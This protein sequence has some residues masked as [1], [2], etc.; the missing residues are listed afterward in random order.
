MSIQTLNDI[1]ST[2]CS[3]HRDRVMLHR[4]ASGWQSISSSDFYR[5]V[6]GLSRALA[7]WGV[8]KGDR[9]AILSENRPEWTITDFAALALGAVTVPI[10]ATQ[11]ADQCAFI[12]NDAGARIVAVSTHHQLEKVLSVRSQTTLERILAMDP[13]AQIG[14]NAPVAPPDSPPSSS[15]ISMGEFMQQGP[16][17]SDPDFDAQARAITPDDLATIIY[18][19]GTTGVSKGVMLTHGNMAS[20]IACSLDGFNLRLERRAQRLLPAALARYRPPCRF[21]APASRRDA[22][23]LPGN[24]ATP[25]VLAEIKPTI[26][27]AVPRVYEKIRQQVILKAA[28]SPRIPS[29][30]GLSTRAAPIAMKSWLAFSRRR[31]H[32]SSLIASSSPKSAPPWAAEP[33]NSSPG[34]RRWVASSPS[35]SPT[36]AFRSTRATV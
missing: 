3:S 11:T 7:S 35:G 33:K 1:L 34:A 25:A 10:Y 28:A 20:N 8:Q 23:L 17:A 19:S 36:S 13:I 14:P 15:I 4:Q 27:V 18:T 5:S 30:D 12:L 16:S 29:I 22:R 24:H 32:G 31:A 9:V 26:F 21:R 2:V 6:V